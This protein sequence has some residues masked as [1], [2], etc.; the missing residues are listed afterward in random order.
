MRWQMLFVTRPEVCRTL[1][2]RPL[3]T[4]SNQPLINAPL[5]SQ[6]VSAR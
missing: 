5:V 1:I 4:R 2:E 6:I 3:A